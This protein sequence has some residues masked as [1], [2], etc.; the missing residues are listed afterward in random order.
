[1]KENCGRK[2]TSSLVSTST[3]VVKN[4]PFRSDLTSAKSP[5]PAAS[6]MGAPPYAYW[7]APILM[8][9]GL[10]IESSVFMA[11]TNQSAKARLDQR[12]WGNHSA[13]LPGSFFPRHSLIFEPRA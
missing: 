9:C 7:R 13:L 4:P 6:W 1:M 8:N 5:L 12:L 11:S 3:L 10:K 2:L